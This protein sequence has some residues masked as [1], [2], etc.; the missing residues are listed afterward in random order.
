ML[1]R[2]KDRHVYRPALSIYSDKLIF[3]RWFG[4]RHEQNISVI[5]TRSLKWCHRIKDKAGTDKDPKETGLCCCGYILWCLVPS[6]FG[7]L[8]CLVEVWE[9]DYRECS[10]SVVKCGQNNVL[11]W[12]TEWT[13]L[14]LR[15]K[16]ETPLF[17]WLSMLDI[18][19][20]FP[21]SRKA[22]FWPNICQISLVFLC[23]TL[24]HISIPQFLLLL[25]Q[26]KDFTS[27]VSD[28]LLWAWHQLCT[29][30]SHPTRYIFMYLKAIAV[31]VH[32][33]RISCSPCIQ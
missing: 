18:V 19:Q 7:P 24:W 27:P 11:L 5:C 25:L 26:S 17:L 15:E 14:L 16:G 8:R 9:Q 30:I 20:G 3:L 21:T 22:I 10:L 1:T 32:W 6:D 13:V 2:L 23:C 33:H 4:I 29:H 28:D 12:S 31:F